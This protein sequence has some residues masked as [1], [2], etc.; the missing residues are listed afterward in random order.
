MNGWM[1]VCTVFA[2]PYFMLVYL[3]MRRVN[4][5]QLVNNNTLCDT[6][7]DANKDEWR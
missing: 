7:T 4:R 6:D 2:H 1:E 5:T 3:V